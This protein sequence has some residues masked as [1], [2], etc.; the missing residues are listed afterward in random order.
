MYSIVDMSQ[1]PLDQFGLPLGAVLANFKEIPIHSNY[2]STNDS[3]Y[4]SV[5]KHD[6]NNSFWVVTHDEN[7]IYSYLV[8]SNVVSSTQVQSYLNI[9]IPS[10]IVGYSTTMRSSPPLNF[11][12]FSNYLLI[13]MHSYSGI[14]VTK[15]L[16][17][18]NITGAVT[19]DYELEISSVFPTVGEFNQ[20]ASILYLGRSNDSKIFSV[21]M[22]NSISFPTYQQIY[23]NQNP[24]FECADIRRNTHNDI[25]LSFSTG[26]EYLSKIVNPNS[27]SNNYLDLDNIYLA[28]KTTN[29]LLP[30]LVYTFDEDQCVNSYTLSSAET[31]VNHIYQASDYIETNG[32][33]EV[34]ATNK[35][36]TMKA[37]KS[38][39]LSPDT[40]IT[41]DSNYFYLATIENC[42]SLRP[43]AKESTI[44]N[45]KKKV[46]YSFEN[47]FG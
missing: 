34:N 9:N 25:Y 20:D 27:Y 14:N 46:K 8:N 42:G 35:N 40:F 47:V 7:L 24:F 19:N 17:F 5:I 2:Q 16:S 38:I 45:S 37:S 11:S 26:Y 30:N 13:N 32:T 12:N 18:N 44:I 39:T 15:V 21:D 29:G 4:F 3:A 23:N 28:G 36:I 43:K 31:N 22:Q 41:T 1:G 6:D 10:N 33:Y